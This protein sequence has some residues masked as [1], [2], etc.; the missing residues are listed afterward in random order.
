MY[1]LYCDNSGEFLA[2]CDSKLKA[3]T[4]A[5]IW[6]RERDRPIVG[7]LSSSTGATTACFRYE[8]GKRA[9][10]AGCCPDDLS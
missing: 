2:R 4:W 7:I 8:K 9:F 1:M 3:M 10:D 6:S 5:A